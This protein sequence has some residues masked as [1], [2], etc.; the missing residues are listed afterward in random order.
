MNKHKNE[1]LTTHELLIKVLSNQHKIMS[2]LEAKKPVRKGDDTQLM[3]NAIMYVNS[4]DRP[5]ITGI[6]KHC[7]VG[8]V[9]ASRI[10]DGLVADRI[11]IR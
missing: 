8:Y 10:M 2:L 6:Q 3:H 11:V 9:K 5:S 1:H 4:T 7:G